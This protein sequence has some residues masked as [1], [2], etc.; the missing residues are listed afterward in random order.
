MSPS[1]PS[2]RKLGRIGVIGGGTAGH[3]AAL[4]LKKQF[5]EREVTLVESSRIPIIGVGEATTP[6]M[7]AFLY[8]RL[9]LD[10]EELFRDVKP[11]M[12]LGIRFDWGPGDGW[13]PYAFG[14]SDLSESAAQD[15]TTL[16]QSLTAL[17]MAA[18]RV[19]V[20]RNDDGTLT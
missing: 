10:A 6:L 2:T 15:G 9:G 4:A 5:P 11:T 18:E 17:L 3:F 20:F 7:L 16:N 19:P 1:A 8:D 14:D 13:F 12:K